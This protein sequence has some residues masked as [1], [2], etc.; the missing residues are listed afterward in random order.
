LKT[1]R[2]QSA[3]F[4][5]AISSHAISLESERAERRKQEYRAPKKSVKAQERYALQKAAREAAGNVD[6]E[7]PRADDN[8]AQLVKRAEQLLARMAVQLARMMQSLTLSSM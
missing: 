4:K 2:D 6:E 1:S 8:R 7:L 5:E 3:E